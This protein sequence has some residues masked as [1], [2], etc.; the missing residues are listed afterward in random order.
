MNTI[1]VY[2]GTGNTIASAKQLATA[3]TAKTEKIRAELTGE[4]AGEVGILMY[5]VFA[6]G[7][8]MEVKR[9][10]KRATFKFDYFAVI[11]TCGSYSKGAFAEAIRLLKRRKQKVHYSDEI[12]SVENFVHMFKLPPQDAIAQIIST[13]KQRTA[14]IAQNIADKKTNRRFLLRPMSSFILW[15]FR[16]ATPMFARRYKFTPACTNCG[17]CVKVCPSG[18]VRPV[19]KPESEHA[20]PTVDAKRCD[21]CQGCLQSC[22]HRAI[23][24]GKIQPESRRYKHP[25]VSID[26]L[27]K[28]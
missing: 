19:T 22:P 2:S 27:F 18:A 10:I 21:F 11:T 24:F 25:D 20:T 16:R 9:F 23:R 15:V 3:L 6:Y 1:F 8:P 17:I 7:M 26:E 14:Q 13:Q 12:R 28:R 4:F 5:P